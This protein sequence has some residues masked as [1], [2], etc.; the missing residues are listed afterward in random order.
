LLLFRNQPLYLVATLLHAQGIKKSILVCIAHS[1]QIGYFILPHVQELKSCC[2]KAMEL[3]FL[4][5]IGIIYEVTI[6]IGECQ[7]ESKN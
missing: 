3:S 2:L 7:Q 5:Y 4:T 1:R 6:S